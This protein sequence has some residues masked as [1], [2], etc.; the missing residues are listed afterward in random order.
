MVYGYPM[1]KNNK[2]P[3]VNENRLEIQRSHRVNSGDTL[4]DLLNACGNNTEAKIFIEHDSS[5]SDV[6]LRYT[7][8]ETDDEMKSRIE[9]EIAFVERMK[10]NEKK[11]KKKKEDQEYKEF[12]RLQKKFLGKKLPI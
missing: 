6:Y 5:Y 4:A 12:L 9:N 7:T 1:S 10:E 8:F 2:Y 3:K 11:I